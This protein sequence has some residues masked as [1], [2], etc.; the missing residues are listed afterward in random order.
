MVDG[1]A[2]DSDHEDPQTIAKLSLKYR[3]KTTTKTKHQGTSREGE[4]RARSEQPPTRRDQAVGAAGKPRMPSPSRDAGT[5]ENATEYNRL[6]RTFGI[7]NDYTNAEEINKL[8]KRGGRASAKISAYQVKNI[9]H[10]FEKN[11]SK[12][13]GKK[14][15][16]LPA[17]LPN[18]NPAE[19]A[20]TATSGTNA[21]NG[22]VLRVRNNLT[23]SKPHPVGAVGRVPA[24]GVSILPGKML[25]VNQRPQ[26]THS[27]DSDGY[28]KPV[29]DPSSR[30]TYIDLIPDTKI[31]DSNTNNN[32]SGSGPSEDEPIYDL[33]TP[34]Y[35]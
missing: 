9:I 32:A 19:L 34:S 15:S 35:G 2:S 31:P 26:S 1:S 29:I 11:D 23:A 27:M 22:V 18:N 7:S 4:R 24:G 21:S 17:N 25:N 10:L 28:M 5:Y 8:K 13:A 20:A 14:S 33:T 12:T 30:T 6:S 16:T 3:D